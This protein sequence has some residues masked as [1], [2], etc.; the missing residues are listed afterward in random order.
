M[1]KISVGGYDDGEGSSNPN[2]KR[3]RLHHN[4]ETDEEEEENQQ[5]QQPQQEQEQEQQPQ[6]EQQ[7]QQHGF[8]EDRTTEED[9]ETVESNT[10]DRSISITLMDPD[11][12]DCCICY[13]PF[14]APIFQ[15][16]NGHIACSNCCS[17]LGNKCPMCSMPIGYNRCRAIEKVLESI[18]MSCLNTKYGC[19]E[20]FNYSK[21]NDHEKE[22]IYIPCLCPHPGCDFVAASKELSLHFSHRHIGSAIP[23]EKN[24]GSLFI[25][26]NSREH[27]GNIVHLGCIGPK[28][29]KGF[30]YEILARSQG[31]SLILTSLTKI[32]QGFF[33]NP[34]STGRL[35]I[36]SDF[37]GA[38]TLKLDI[39]IRSRQQSLTGH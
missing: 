1:V 9:N 3:R 15:C 27:L 11:V 29:I 24:D 22:C 21:K 13:E 39:R 8:E 14:S 20:K 26:H 6:Q 35:L 2:Q 31:S 23:F 17:R 7:Q 5:Q 25:V 34:P 12:L 16:E 4:D 19:K 33:P 28:S 36:P 18:K 37:F 30:H 38:G 32:I 10:R